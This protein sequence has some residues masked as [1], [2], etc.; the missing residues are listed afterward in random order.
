MESDQL[1]PRSPVELKQRIEA[2]RRALPFLLYRD[3]GGHQQML[4]L[5][6]PSP[7]IAIGR[8]PACDLA[9]PWDPQVSRAHAELE[10]IGDE[11]TIVD[12]GRSQNGSFVNGERL[13]GRRRLR[14]GDVV[15]VGKTLL[16]FHSPADG[17]TAQTA[18]PSAPPMGPIT[19]A[20][21][22]VLIALCRPYATVAV[23]APASNQQIA[24]ELVIEL[25]TVKKHLRALFEVFG[26]LE[27][28]Q[29]Q[30]RS[31]LARRAL[32]AGV[33]LPRELI[34]PARAGT[35]PA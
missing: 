34:P 28:A 31:E 27:L 24:D 21:R 4:D 30:K 15:R 11:W 1:H 20:Q 18:Q 10:R 17:D 9:L 29:N 35:R 12:D 16:A 25:D 33:V 7:R 32:Q 13:H 22:R 2:D 6:K 3:G 19:D 5:G 14:D 23:G 8:Q 26:I